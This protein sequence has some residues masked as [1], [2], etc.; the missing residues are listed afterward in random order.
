[1]IG[2]F[3]LVTALVLSIAKTRE[4]YTIIKAMED[5]S[6]RGELFSVTLPEDKIAIAGVVMTDEEAK[7]FFYEYKDGCQVILERIGDQTVEVF[8]RK[9]RTS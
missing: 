6:V 4:L 1:V 3:A 7:K 2:G 8:R 5:T 9:P